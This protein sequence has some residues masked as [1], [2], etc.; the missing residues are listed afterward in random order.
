M[1]APLKDVPQLTQYSGRASWQGSGQNTPA[2][3]KPGSTVT[4]H[5]P[6]DLGRGAGEFEAPREAIT[7][8]AARMWSSWRWPRNQVGNCQCC[9]GGGN[10]EMIDKP[11]L[12]ARPSA[13]RKI[14][15][16]LDT[17]AEAV[18]SACQQCVRTMA[19]YTRRNK[20]KLKVMDI[21]QLIHRALD[22]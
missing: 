19:T 9:G 12:I 10:L 17:G 15:Q 8:D 3:K 16:V 21:T 4:Y 5:D 20:V 22:V 1:I 18:I 2:L 7:S 11:N 6:C 13:K 14:D